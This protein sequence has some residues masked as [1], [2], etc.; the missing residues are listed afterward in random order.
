MHPTS[1]RSFL[2]G[3]SLAVAA[4]A[5]S[6]I[7]T[8]ASAAEFTLRYANN[9]P[10]THPM[11]MRAKEMAS[12]ILAE[13]KG[14]VDIQ[15]FPSNQLGSDT[16][17]LSQL[18]SGAVDFFTLSPLILGTFVPEAQISGIGFAFKSYDEVW[19]A[20][21]GDLGAHVRAKIGTTSIFA[22]EKIWN[23]G[24]RQI[25]TSERPVAHPKDLKGLKLRVPPSPLWTS[26]FKDLGTSPASVNFA[27]VYSALQTHVVEGQENPLSI[28]YTAKLYEVQ[29]FCA[30]SNHMWDGFWFLANK[31]SFSRLPRE[32]QKIVADAINDAGVKQRQDVQRLDQTLRAKLESAGLRFNEIDTDAFRKQLNLSGFYT[33]WRSKFGA[34]TWGLLEKY[35]GTLG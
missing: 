20:L 5:L 17:T 16:D 14:R 10:V 11:N 22:F 33:D 6:L 30:L 21:D 19:K 7:S 32:L 25:T 31:D 28:I 8:R 4:P 1:R 9:L 26:M 2:Q 3:I 12:R 27:E 29:K 13:S 35:T 34:E 23:G 18:R 24:F 15:V